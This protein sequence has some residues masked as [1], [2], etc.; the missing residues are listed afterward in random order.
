MKIFVVNLKNSLDRKQNIIQ[1]CEKLDIEVEFFEAVYGK[2]LSE[3]Q[4][5]EKVFGYPDIILSKGEIGCSLSHIE[6]YKEIVKRKLPYALILEDDTTFSEKFPLL[7]EKIKQIMQ[8]NFSDEPAVLLLN[9]AKARYINSGAI[10]LSE[11]FKIHKAFGSYCTD[12]YI[13][14]LKAAENLYSLLYPVKFEADRWGLFY[15]LG[16]VNLYKLIPSLFKINGAY[17]ST[18][19]DE[20]RERLFITRKQQVTKMIKNLPVKMRFN[21]LLNRTKVNLNPFMRKGT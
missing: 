9:N 2:E 3:E 6:L 11:N 21:L 5:K 19:Q 8:N 12:S 17:I 13:V 15:Q 16:V 4:L 7:I 10:S 20:E 14:N 1:Q 18:I